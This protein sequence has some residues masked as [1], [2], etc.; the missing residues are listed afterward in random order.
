[1]TTD[2]NELVIRIQ[3]ALKAYAV[4]NKNTIPKNT[5]KDIIGSNCE[6]VKELET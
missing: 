5:L 6:K 1:M 2:Y 3:A 4:R